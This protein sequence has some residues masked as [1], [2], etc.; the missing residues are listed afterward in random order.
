ME[1][2]ISLNKCDPRTDISGVTGGK[3]RAVS[4]RLLKIKEK[5]KTKKKKKKQIKE[6]FIISLYYVKRNIPTQ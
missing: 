5:H 2:L 6:N 1:Y 4:N 3:R